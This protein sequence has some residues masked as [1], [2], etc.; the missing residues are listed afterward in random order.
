MFDPLQPPNQTPLESALG[1]LEA[2]R[3]AAI[4]PDIILTLRDPW[5]CPAELLPWLAWELSVEEWDDDWREEIKRQVIADSF[6]FHQK[7]GTPWAVR[8]VF[9]SLG[10]GEIDI[11]EGRGG[12]RR[13]GTVRRSAFPV[14]GDKTAGWAEYRIVCHHLLTIKQSQAALRMLAHAAPAR[15]RLFEIDFAGSA[16]IRNGIARR[17]GTYTRGIVTT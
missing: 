9:R 2:E 17:D 12:H 14:R 5:A 8:Q 4:D 6:A 1:L 11:E 7:K 3:I 10:L 13:D 16:L 15:S